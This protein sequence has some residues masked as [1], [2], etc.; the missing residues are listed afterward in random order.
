[1]GYTGLTSVGEPHNGNVVLGKSLPEYDPEAGYKQVVAP[2]I[3]A[4]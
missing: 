4:Q 2:F 1:M 3:T